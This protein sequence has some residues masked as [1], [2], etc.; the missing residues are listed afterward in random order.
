MYP[1]LKKILERRESALEEGGKV[2]WALAEAL[3]LATIL[4]DGK[5][6]RL[7][8]Q[9]SERG[10]FA[11]RHI[12][13]HDSETNETYSPLHR[14]PQ[15]KASFAI[16]NSPLS[17][18]A[19]V[20]FEYGYNVFAPETLV[21]WEAQYGDFANTA[22]ALFD[23]FVSAGRAKWGQKSGLVLLL[24]HGYEGQ[25]PEHSSAR[26][27]RFLQ[28]A[29]EKQL[30]SRKLNERRSI[31][32]YFTPSGCFTGN[33]VCASARNHDTEK[34]CSATRLLLHRLKN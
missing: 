25:G 33:G 18:A 22:Q 11:Q 19:V 1:K 8:G 28:L 12:V 23:Q 24:P 21:L 29:A 20:G 17:E 30:D 27:E 31:L 14:L 34:V 7:T 2:E 32:P 16:H 4:Q 15:A 10:T 26:P 3:A 5:P 13:L 6:I 9:D